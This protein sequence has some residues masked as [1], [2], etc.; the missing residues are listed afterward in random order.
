MYAP[1]SRSTAGEVRQLYVHQ[2]P[3]A[4]ACPKPRPKLPP[5]P[6]LDKTN[7]SLWLPR[8]GDAC[9]SLWRGAW[10]PA[11]IVTVV[12]PDSYELHYPGW[13]TQHNHATSRKCLRHKDYDFDLDADGWTTC[14][15]D[16]D[17][18][19][20]YHDH[21]DCDDYIYICRDSMH[22]L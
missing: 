20:G 10:Y 8:R 3:P 2:P 5:A 11:K 15:G 13:G 1:L 7:E 4:A 9:Y 6:K 19:Y 17:D 22:T 18:N 21:H 16:C 12:S 14:L